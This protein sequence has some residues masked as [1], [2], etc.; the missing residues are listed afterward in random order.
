MYISV[1]QKDQ[2]VR[3]AHNYIRISLFIALFGAI[4]E[5]FSHEVYSYHMIYAFVIPL[6]G[7]ALPFLLIAMG[8]AKR[9]PGKISRSLYH[10]GIATLTV[11]SI[12]SGILTIYGTYQQ[13]ARCLLDHWGL[14]D[15]RRGSHERCISCRLTA[16]PYSELAL[17]DSN[18]AAF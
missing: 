7:G 13:S 16:Y 3:T 5:L 14:T 15:H 9:Y 4:Y 8:R 18:W 2:A 1:N 6:A 11:G 10:A 12:M 17:R